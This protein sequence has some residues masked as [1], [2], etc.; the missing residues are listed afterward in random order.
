MKGALWLVSISLFWGAE[1]SSWGQ[2]AD[3][4]TTVLHLGQTAERSVL[5]DR[6][7]IELRVEETGADPLTLQSAINRRMA[8][9]L[10]RARQ[11]QGVQLATGSYGVGE[12]RPQNGPSRWRAT[13]SGA[14][15]GTTATA[16][17]FSAVTTW[18]SD[19]SDTAGL[20]SP[21]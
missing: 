18:A 21:M 6:L 11:V 2:T 7:R 5:R 8:A 9:A 16:V 19:H 20:P 12:E 1:A 13:Q 4:Q 3:Q 10:D 17:A 15:S 14:I